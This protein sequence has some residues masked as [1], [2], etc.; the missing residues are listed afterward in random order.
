MYR[1]FILLHDASLY[2]FSTELVKISE[3]S[4]L[5][6]PS[7]NLWLFKLIAKFLRLSILNQHFN[8]FLVKAMSYNIALSMWKHKSSEGR[9]NKQWLLFQGDI[10]TAQSIFLVLSQAQIHQSAT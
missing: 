3:I 10:S 1:P 8:F 6:G 5:A 4:L 9:S 7:G 2:S